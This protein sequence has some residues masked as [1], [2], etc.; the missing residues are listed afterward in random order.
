MEDDMFFPKVRDKISANNAAMIVN[1][2]AKVDE[3]IQLL[4]NKK[5]NKAI[6][7]QL[8]S[9]IA[10]IIGNRQK[11]DM[12]INDMITKI[13]H[14]NEDLKQL[15]INNMNR[16]NGTKIYKGKEIK[17][18]GKYVGEF[19]NGLRDGKGI[20]YT[21][22]GSVYDGEYKNDI[23]EGKG[24]N[25]FNTGE[26]KGEKYEGDFKNNTWNGKGVYYWNDG[27][28]YEGDFKDGKSE[29]KGIMYYADGDRYEGDFKN[30]KSEG[31][32]VYYY[33]NGDRE[34]GDFRDD[35]IIGMS[36]Y[37]TK[38]GEIFSKAY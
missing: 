35:K 26:F 15:I 19:K 23:R 37:L 7:N 31:K 22:D 5:S 13:N 3:I 18:S 34:M 24:I 32:G 9:I 12:L 28:R 30:G 17:D 25:Y 4:R 33:V 6:I 1:V 2:R 8:K 11:L 20:F 16:T 29:G 38:D 14:I 36:V 10:I 27:D 21:D